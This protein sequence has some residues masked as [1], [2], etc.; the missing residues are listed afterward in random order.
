M[1]RSKRKEITGWGTAVAVLTFLALVFAFYVMVEGLRIV[2]CQAAVRELEARAEVAARYLEAPLKTLDFARI[3]RFGEECRKRGYELEISARSGG[4]LFDTRENPSGSASEW[5][6]ASAPCGENRI[7]L[8]RPIAEVLVPYE[9]AKRLF[10]V[11]AL[12]GAF[13]MFVVFFALY[14]QHV[15]IRE[16]AKV[17]K[18][19]REF[20]AD[21]S[22]EIKTPLTGILGAVEMLDEVEKVG[23]VG[24][25]VGVGVGGGGG[26]HAR[27]VGMIGKES[28]RLNALVQEILDLARFEREG[29]K[30][31]D[32]ETDLA[33]LVSDL[34]AKYRTVRALADRPVKVRCDPVLIEQAIANLVENAKRHSGSDDITVALVPPSSPG[35]SV[36]IVVEDKGIGIPSEHLNRIFE[37]FHRVD[38]A[39]AA[40]SGGAGL[41]LSIVRRIARLHGGDVAC[42]NV[43]PHGARFTISIPA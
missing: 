16:L 24:V 21:L 7:G 28:K 5:I 10:V 22:H 23:G 14:R 9:R 12:I 38:P 4:C 1:G 13:G 36:R 25:G 18:F 11:S 41:G 2:I 39:R 3:R 40:E 17:E 35:A 15:R 43:V 42:E 32:V 29:E 27:L 33:A 19:R 30:L 20:I 8:C 6:G 34:A 37:R 31:N 26:V